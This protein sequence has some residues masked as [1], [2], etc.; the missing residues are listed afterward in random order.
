[1]RK[2]TCEEET[3]EEGQEVTAN[4]G[5]VEF[6]DDASYEDEEGGG[7]GAGNDAAD[8]SDEEEGA[9]L[10]D[11]DESSSMQIARR[12]IIDT[13]NWQ[14]EADQEVLDCASRLHQQVLL[15]QRR[16]RGFGGC[17]GFD[18]CDSDDDRTKAATTRFRRRYYG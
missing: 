6:A 14:L 7:P 2:E 13:T 16:S 1:V 3:S 8:D 15:I 4:D 11:D 10:D 18:F 12:H 5:G 9:G 17:G